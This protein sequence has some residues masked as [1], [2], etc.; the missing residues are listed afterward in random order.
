MTH[1]SDFDF[2]KYLFAKF[3][4]PKPALGKMRLETSL[5]IMLD[6]AARA[7]SGAQFATCSTDTY[8]FV[9]FCKPLLSE[10]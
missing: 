3:K 8:I 7:T 2:C 4:A 5:G 6:V 1:L 10:N 9:K